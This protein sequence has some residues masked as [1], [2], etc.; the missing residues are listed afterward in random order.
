MRVIHWYPNFLNGG[1]VA[2]A[3]ARLALSQASAGA[4]V[5][6]AAARAEGQV[7]YGGHGEAAAFVESW[8]PAWRVSAGGLMLRG[9]SRI[10]ARRFFAFAPDVVHAHGEFDPDNLW[11]PRIF[12]APLVLSPRGA[13][14]PMVLAKSHAL[15]KRTYIAVAKRALYRHLAAFHATSPMEAEHI[16]TTYPSVPIYQVPPGVPIVGHSPSQN[17]FSR[18]RGARVVFVFVGRL[19]VFTKGLDLLLDA[20]HEVSRRSPCPTKLKLVGPDWRGGR[21]L[22]EERTRKL[23]ISELVDLVGEVTHDEVI[24]HLRSSDVCA[25]VSRHES[26]S[27]SAAEALVVGM[28]V[29]MSSEVGLASYSEI[30]SLPHVLVVQPDFRSI[31]R[32]FREVL[33]RLDPL[34]QSASETRSRL[35]S[36]FSLERTAREHLDFYSRVQDRA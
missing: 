24:H 4:D 28:P 32:A 14:H 3:T 6:I 35:A 5:L 13:F 11:L 31:V 29:V 27:S 23:G 9:L 26:F 33:D 34:T 18:S 10:D 21:R 25:Q 1:A 30:G 2:A 7:L 17:R 19:D 12:E 15:A 22:L 20:F 16:R 36:F 8:R